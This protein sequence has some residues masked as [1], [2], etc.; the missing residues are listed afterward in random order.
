MFLERESAN[1]AKL[2][3]KNA[4]NI[5]PFRIFGDSPNHFLIRTGPIEDPMPLQ[6]NMIPTAIA[7]PDPVNLRIKAYSAIMLTQLPN[8]EITCPYHRFLKE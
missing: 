1:R 6:E 7:I 3:R 8:S 4:E 2:P 5:A